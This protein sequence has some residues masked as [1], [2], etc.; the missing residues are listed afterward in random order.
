MYNTLE[1]LDAYFADPGFEQPFFWCE[2]LH[3]MGNG[4]G[5]VQDHWDYIYANPSMMG[6]CA[7]EWC[8]HAI[9]AG[10]QKTEDG[11]ITT[12]AT[13]ERPSMT[14]ISAVTAW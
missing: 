13:A 7:W 6:G 11:G 4:P 5:S 1:L 2:F 14:A 3:A 9:D 8:D 12:A 10:V